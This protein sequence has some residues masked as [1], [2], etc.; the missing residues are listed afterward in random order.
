MDSRSELMELYE[1][2]KEAMEELKTATLERSPRAGLLNQRVHAAL[3]AY[4]RAMEREV[5]KISAPGRPQGVRRSPD[6]YL[7]GRSS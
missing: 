7:P 4:L 2:W 3:D 1:E 6:S 5:G